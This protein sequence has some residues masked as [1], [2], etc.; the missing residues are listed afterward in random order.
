[1]TNIYIADLN[2]P[3]FDFVLEYDHQEFMTEL[4]E[5]QDVYWSNARFGVANGFYGKKH[6][7][8]VQDRITEKISKR[9]ILTHPNGRQENIINLNMY[10]KEN[11]LNRDSLM[12]V[13]NTGN[14]VPYPKSRRKP[15][16]AAFATVGYK[17]DMI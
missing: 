5:D 9:Y 15:T 4:R 16:A 2:D 8:E 3:M 13:M 17:L 14:S 6:S 11:G 10:C 12:K 7:K 1:M